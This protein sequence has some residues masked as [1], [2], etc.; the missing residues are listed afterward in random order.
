M[1][2]DIVQKVPEAI[3]RAKKKCFER[4]VEI[5]IPKKEAALFEKEYAAPVVS[6]VDH[7]PLVLSECLQSHIVFVNGIFCPELSETS[8]L[9]KGCT[10]LPLKEAYR[11]FSTLLTANMNG[12]AKECTNPF[13][14]M[15]AAL[16]DEGVCILLAPK[17]T[18]TSPLQ[19]ISIVDGSSV[20]AASRVHLFAGS[21]SELSIIHTSVNQGSKDS[22]YNLCFD[23]NLED[24]ASIRYES[25]YFGSGEAA[26]SEL[27]CFEAIQ[28]VL[29]RD[30][31]FK[32]TCVEDCGAIRRDI[33]VIL[34]GVQAE[35]ECSGLWL[36]E[37][38]K[39]H[40]T[41]CLVEHKEPNARS[42]QYFKGVLQDSANAHFCGQIIVR[43]KAQKTESYQ[44]NNNLLLS[45]DAVAKVDPNLEIFADDVK[46]SHGATIG[47][48]DPEALFYMRSRGVS[49][50]KAKA[51][52]VRGFC[53]EVVAK[54][55]IRSLQDKA[56]QSTFKI[57]H[58][59]DKI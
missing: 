41:R 37:G 3:L 47:Q 1:P 11:T 4:F 17:A 35:A 6:S 58:A 13:F 9:V 36:L 51:L 23:Y 33:R 19:I 29:K 24:N 21:S 53:E 49:P 54:L 42:M 26:E 55:S 18:F 34:N 59:N 14:L 43:K 27:V 48:L 10:I 39:T 30:A 16:S 50:D 12:L 25:G 8:A 52:I 7:L 31:R 57:V 20:S 5:G 46:A 2:T 22:I 28:A 40:H 45:D 32:T 44:L 38:S 56:Y 15:N